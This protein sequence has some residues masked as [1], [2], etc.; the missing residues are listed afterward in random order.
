MGDVKENISKNLA[1]YMELNGLNNKELSRLL[2]VSE[3]TV[4]KWLLKKATPRMGM[5]EKLATL[6][7]VKK[8]ALLENNPEA[9]VLDDP[10]PIILAR[11][12]KD[13]SSGQID[14]IRAM[15]DEFKNNGSD[16]G[17]K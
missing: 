5:V 14:I 8:S 17:E 11:D 7:N 4:G 12:L 2:G 1:Y 15:I 9:V 13:L 16:A 10:T 3:S 6:F